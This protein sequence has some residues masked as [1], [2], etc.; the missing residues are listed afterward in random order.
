[1][2]KSKKINHNNSGF[3][4]LRI[5]RPSVVSFLLL[6]AILITIGILLVWSAFSYVDEVTHAEGRIIPSSRMQIVQNMEGGIVRS[7][8]VKQGDVVE[9]DDVVLQMES[10]QYSSELDS[11]KQQVMSLMAKQARLQA[12]VNDQS[13]QFTKEFSAM[14]SQYVQTEMSEFDSRRRRLNADVN[15]LESQLNSG[16]QELEIVKKRTERGLEPQIELV[17]TQARVDELRNK[18]ESMKRQF[19]SESATELSRVV[20]ELNPLRQ[21]LPAFA[22]KLN[23]TQ[24]KAPLKGVVNRVM[25]NTVGGVIKPGEPIVEIVPFDDTLVVEAQ[26]RP[27][28][29]GFIH[30]GQSANVK[31]TA[32]DYSIFG[33]LKGQITNI[34][35]DS[36]SKEERGQVMYYYV[37]RI[38]T[39][40]K[41]IQSLEKNLPIIPGMQAQVDI[42][43]GNKS[44]LSYLLKP[45]IGVKENAFRER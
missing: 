28:D 7:I 39:S 40:A 30:L 4:N 23:R 6:N 17:R 37:A 2:F 5:G 38:E 18:I 21:T 31:I 1:M 43:T 20:L 10:V 12:E 19:K 26:I 9:K 22:D 36:V 33:S 44:V 25:V 24:V 16:Q 8:N 15:L 29:I 41:V 42:I 27:Q 34:S 11:K 35:P 32:Y 3:G 14:A 45:L 13:L